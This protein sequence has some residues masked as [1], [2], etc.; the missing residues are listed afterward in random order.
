MTTTVSEQREGRGRGGRSRAAPVEVTA[1]DR[2]THHLFQPL[3]YHVATGILSE[4][5]VA[6]PIRDVLR[7][8]RN[9]H[10]VL[11]EVGG[12]DLSRKTVACTPLDR[13]WLLPYDSLVVAAGSAPSSRIRDASCCRCPVSAAASL[14]SSAARSGSRSRCAIS[15]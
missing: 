10:V 4:G 6:P 3:L 14:R 9:A 13:T 15:S 12:V 7:H 5:N 8:Q 11:A 2:Q 1:I